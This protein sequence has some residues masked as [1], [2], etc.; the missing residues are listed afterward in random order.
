MAGVT[1]V[2]IVAEFL[3]EQYGRSIS[4][5]GSHKE[6]AEGFVQ[7]VEEAGRLGDAEPV[8]DDWTPSDDDVDDF[9]GAGVGGMVRLWRASEIAYYALIGLARTGRLLPRPAVPGECPV[10]YRTV[11]P[12][13]DG[14][15][16]HHRPPPHRSDLAVPG[17]NCKGGYR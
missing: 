6:I 12:R 11:R 1:D 3:K 17:G 10:C 4:H 7:A 13:Q 15:V 16:R 8:G 14:S 9:A 2:E 5:I